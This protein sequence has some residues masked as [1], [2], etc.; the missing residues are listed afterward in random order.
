MGSFYAYFSE[1][2]R[3]IGKP[4]L[5]GVFIQTVA[6][7]VIYNTWISEEDGKT[8]KRTNVRGYWNGN[9]LLSAGN[10]WTEYITS[11]RFVIITGTLPVPEGEDAV[12]SQV[13]FPYPE[14]LTKDNCVIISVE[15]MISSRERWHYGFTTGLLGA[16]NVTE[17]GIV[18]VTLFSDEIMVAGHN[19]VFMGDKIGRKYSEPVNYK[20]VLLK[21]SGI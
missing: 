17:G 7:H 9:E 4:S 12:E 14:G 10:S 1:E 8:Y 19:L 15:K 3:D 13:R 5:T 20:I 21:T 18:A 6:N 16:M 2:F 11:D